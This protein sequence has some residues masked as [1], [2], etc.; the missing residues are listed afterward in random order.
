MHY[1]RPNPEKAA[2]YGAFLHCAAGG[3]TAN[4]ADCKIAHRKLYYSQTCS[5]PCAAGAEGADRLAI[6]TTSVEQEKY[7]PAGIAERT[8][9][10]RAAESPRLPAG[11]CPFRGTEH[12]PGSFAPNPRPEVPAAVG[13]GGSR[14][15]T[16]KRREPTVSPHR[17]PPA[18]GGGGSQAEWNRI[19]RA[20]AASAAEAFWRE[21]PAGRRARCAE[22]AVY[23]NSFFRG[24]E[25]CFVG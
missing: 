21:R 6:Q 9:G 14:R 23:A 19:D 1:I 25:G 4:P 22:R 7:V 3:M 2:K 16:R 12:A 13:G 5:R 17:S 8:T 10:M 18:N 11:S 15:Y 24:W 20:S